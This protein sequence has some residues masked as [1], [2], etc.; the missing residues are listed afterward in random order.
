MRKSLFAC[1]YSLPLS[2]F[3]IVGA[4]AQ[5]LTSLSE[6]FDNVGLL[7]GAGWLNVNNSSPLGDHNWNQGIPGTGTDGFGMNAQS[8]PANSFIQTDFMA[9]AGGIVSDWLITPVLLLE[10]GATMSFYTAANPAPPAG[11]LI[12]SVQR[13]F[14]I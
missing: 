5:P 4:R 10:N 11:G 12:D 9:G 2:T 6:G 8:G 14:S 1:V 3:L 13:Q 7:A